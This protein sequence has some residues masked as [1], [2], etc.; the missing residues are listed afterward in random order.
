MIYEFSVA[1]DKNGLSEYDPATQEKMDIDKIR[2][3]LKLF[4]FDVPEDQL[5]YI[6]INTFKKWRISFTNNFTNETCSA[7]YTDSCPAYAGNPSFSGED[8]GFLGQ[9]IENDSV[10][11]MNWFQVQGKRYSYNEM[12]DPVYVPP[13]A[14]NRIP[15]IEEAIFSTKTRD[16]DF[17]LHVQKANPKSVNKTNFEVTIYKGSFKEICHSPF[18]D[19]M[20]FDDKR[21]IV[22]ISYGINKDYNYFETG[23]ILNP[24]PLNESRYIYGRN[25]N[26]LTDYRGKHTLLDNRLVYGVDHH[27]SNGAIYYGVISED[28]TNKFENIHPLGMHLAPPLQKLENAEKKPISKMYFQG[29]YGTSGSKTLGIVKTESGIAVIQDELQYDNNSGFRKKLG[30]QRVGKDTFPSMSEGSRTSA[31]IQEVIHILR[32]N[33]AMNKFVSSICDELEIFIERKTERT[34]LSEMEFQVSDICIPNLAVHF[35]TDVIINMILVQGVDYSVSNILNSYSNMFRTNKQ[36]I[37]NCNGNIS[38]QSVT[39]NYEE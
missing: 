34:E 16:G 21:K 18:R 17:V 23:S 11:R 39:P 9:I 15:I 5:L 19:A 32:Q 6:Q 30:Y 24:G 20:E 13:Y 22:R 12:L 2:A 35:D 1:Q 8:E 29:H 37:I 10:I 7:F 31:E 33:Y 25:M 27:E 36:A 4:A 14:R 38:K 28:G 26:A 3:L